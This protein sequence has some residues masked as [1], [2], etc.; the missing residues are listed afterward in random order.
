LTE[1]F[2]VEIRI[3]FDS[4]DHA[5]MLHFDK[6]RIVIRN[7]LEITIFLIIKAD[8]WVFFIKIII[9]IHCF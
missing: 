7:G 8:I 1:L 6:Y 5:K 3:I 4:H 2:I 9:K